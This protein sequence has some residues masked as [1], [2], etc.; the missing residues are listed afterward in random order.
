MRMHVHV[1]LLLQVLLLLPLTGSSCLALPAQLFRM[2]AGEDTP[3][4]GAIQ[5]LLLY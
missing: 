2:I 5:V 4:K 1:I 3:D